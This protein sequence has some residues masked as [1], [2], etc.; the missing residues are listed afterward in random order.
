[1]D[2]NVLI[3]RPETEEL[4][5]W[6]IDSLNARKPSKILD[7][8]CGSGCIPVALAVKLPLAEV[9]A[10]DVSAKA[11]EIARYNAENLNANVQ[12]DRIN[13][14]EAD[15]LDKKFD[16]IVSNPPYVRLSE[17]K[18]MR[19][20]VLK[21]EP[22]IALFVNDDD[23][24]LFYRKISSLAKDGLTSEGILFFEINEELAESTCKILEAFEFQNIEIRKDIFGRDRMIRAFKK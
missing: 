11:L 14:L 21:H 10:L 16:V 23:P 12:F 5:Y 18:L 6:I 15:H 9:Q 7:I 22:E 8:G 17:K 2:E 19:G 3:P 20:N 13:I 24:L 4:V 1:L